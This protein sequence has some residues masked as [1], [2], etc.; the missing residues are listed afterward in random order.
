MLK[1]GK[2]ENQLHWNFDVLFKEDAARARRGYAAENLSTVRKLALQI[3]KSH[4][5]KR[6]L[7]RRRRM[8]IMDHNYLMLMLSNAIF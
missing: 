5:D 8:A 2:N 6:S 1:E 3:V 4:N 7:R